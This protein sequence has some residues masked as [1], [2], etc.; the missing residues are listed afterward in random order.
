MKL[1]IVESPF[2]GDVE[3]NER[4]ARACI[5]DCL[6]RG[7]APFASHLLYTQPGIVDDSNDEERARS[8]VG[9][10]AWYQVADLCAIYTDRGVSVGMEQG[11]AAAV[12]ALVEIQ[13]RSLREWRPDQGWR[14]ISKIEP[15]KS[16]AGGPAETAEP[17]R[18]RSWQGG[19]GR[20]G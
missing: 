17:G 2:A 5:R 15:V 14:H 6:N 18:L 8:I 12:E 11:I 13:H 3:E 4:Y 1:V 7:E 10:H 20:A 19:A 16:Y 9:G